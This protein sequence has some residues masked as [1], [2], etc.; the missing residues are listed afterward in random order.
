M[1]P[2]VF[3]S[4]SEPIRVATAIPEKPLDRWHVVEERGS[5]FVIAD[6]SCGDEEAE[7]ASLAIAENVQLC[8][9]T[10]FRTANQASTPPF[11]TAMLVA[12][13]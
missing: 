3:Q 1:D 6:L 12:V 9:H 5:A 10:T 8:V 4:F 7:R 13:R 11:L 2:L